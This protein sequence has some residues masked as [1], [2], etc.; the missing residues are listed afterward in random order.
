MKK[1][2][3]AALSAAAL[4]LSGAQAVELSYEGFIDP[5]DAGNGNIVPEIDYI[6]FTVTNP[7]VYDFFVDAG[8]AGYMGSALDSFLIVA[9]DDGDITADDIIDANDD[10]G[11]G[12]DSALSLNLGVGSFIAAVSTCCIDGGEYEAGANLS[13]PYPGGN[14]IYQ[15]RIDG[16]FDVDAV[17]VP[18]AAFLFAGPALVAARRQMKKRKTA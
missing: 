16:D 14:L 13:F 9:V 15:L 1:T 2:I 11:P 17:P 8:G 10:G 18:A 7:G 3:C 6:F 12:F 4:G 5:F